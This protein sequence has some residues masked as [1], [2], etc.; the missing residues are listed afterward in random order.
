MADIDPEHARHLDGRLLLVLRELLRTGSATATAERLHLSQS[1]VSH[2]LA[3]LRRIHDDPLFVRRP[4]GLEPTRRAIELG[5]RVDAILALAADLHG[6]PEPFEPRRSERR[7][8]VAMPEF[9]VATVGGE[10]LRRWST[11]APG[12]SLVTTQSDHSAVI[13]ELRRGELD[14]GVGRFGSGTPDG[15]TRR[16]LYRDEYCVVVRDAHPT[17]GASIEL[18]TFLDAGHVIAASRSEGD[19]HEVVPRGIRITAVVPAWLTA[20]AIVGAS[21]AI[22]TCPRRL[23]ERHAAT[24]GLRVVAL[25]G[26]TVP[27]EVSTLERSGRSND[28]AGWLVGQL[29]Q[30]V[31]PPDHAD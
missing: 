20:L 23:A 24:F 6:G 25:P 18:T 16:L 11:T 2:A 13:D 10:L 12:V 8:S 15:L 29:H 27:I 30:V 9:V 21:D 7:F 3:R 19:E 22:A 4:H 31:A 14:L 26:D 1:A 5:P 17:I 28:A